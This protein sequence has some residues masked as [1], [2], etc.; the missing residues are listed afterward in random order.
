MD[1]I[2]AES[3]TS[4]T[5]WILV[6]EGKKILNVSTI[7]FNPYYYSS[8]ELKKCI[9]KDVL[10]HFF[11]Y[12]IEKLFFYGSGISTPNK[13][14]L[15]KSILDISFPGTYIEVNH[16]LLAAARGLFMN[17]PGI[18]C[19][20]GTGSNS[21]VYDGNSITHN[22]P[23]VGYFFGD[24]GS[25]THIG[26]LFIEDYLRDQLPA[27]IKKI[28]EKEHQITFEYVLDKIY[29]QPYPNKFLASFSPFVSQNI[30]NTYLYELVK[31]AFRDFFK[32]FV[33]KYPD[34]QKKMLCFVGSVAY[35]FKEVLGD[36][37]HEF[38]LT[39][40]NIQK[41]PIEGLIEYH[42]K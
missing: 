12:K 42:I 15:V 13:Q 2:I 33:I 21:C 8:T 35:I 26:K 28:V 39:I 14:N 32:E 3:G 23:S 16:D 30:S 17:N 37:A 27:E 5:D 29:S 6:K 1:F 24:E 40:N 19:I 34:Y 36:V 9:E 20:L 25:G 38:G 31:N 10:K 41:S 22:I 7:G 18:A 4:K 11:P